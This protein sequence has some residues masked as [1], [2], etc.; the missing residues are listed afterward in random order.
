[1]VN[2][3]TGKL[4]NWEIEADDQSTNLPMYQS[5]NLPIYQP[6]NLPTYQ[7]TNLAQNGVMV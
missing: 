1:M 7:S 2:W 5:T 6:T 4:V 3:E